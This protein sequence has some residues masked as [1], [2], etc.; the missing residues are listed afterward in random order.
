VDH[1]GVVQAAA[2]I[3]SNIDRQASR[4]AVILD[5]RVFTIILPDDFDQ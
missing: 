5:F 2:T 4:V 3:T 1:H